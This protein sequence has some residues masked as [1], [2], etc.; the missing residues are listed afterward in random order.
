MS[1]IEAQ[2]TE[3]A[4]AAKASYAAANDA[5][6]EKRREATEFVKETNNDDAFNDVNYVFPVFVIQNMPIGVV[7]LII[8]AI[9][10]A[11]MSSVAAELN[12]LAT[13]STMDFYKR[14]FK[15]DGS[16]R[17][18]VAFRPPGNTHLGYFRLHCRDLCHESRLTDRG[19]EHV[20]LLFLRLAPWRL[21][22]R[23]RNTRDETGRRLL[24]PA[25]WYR[26]G[27]DRERLYRHRV[28][29]V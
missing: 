19:R 24:W 26:I 11:A 9:L 10:A 17:E 23:V 2:G 5:Y 4:V 21:R 8:A 15:P 12:S 28:S 25:V 29:L 3:G 14:H 16:S 6:L 22:A 18:L 20:R 7:G 13:A 27:L 1:F